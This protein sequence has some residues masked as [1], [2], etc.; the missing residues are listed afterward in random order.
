MKK[1][2]TISLPAAAGTLVANLEVEQVSPY[3]AIEAVRKSWKKALKEGVTPF[4]NSELAQLVPIHNSSG[5]KSPSL[6]KR[7]VKTISHGRNILE[8]DGLPNIKLAV[9]PEKR[10][11][12]F[13][14]HHS[15]LAYFLAGKKFLREIPYL[16]LGSTNFEP[17]ETSEISLFFPKASRLLVK[18]NWFRYTVNWQAQED[19]QLEERRVENLSDLAAE[20]SKGNKAPSQK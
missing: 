2:L 9:T 12:V 6:V 14:G 18:E 4:A 20:F 3:E 5:I 16:V 13:D 10:L 17:V 8:K 7:M 1:R 15:L 19:K 11:L